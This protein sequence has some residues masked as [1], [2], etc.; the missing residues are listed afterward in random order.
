MLRNAQLRIGLQGC[1][2]V[3]HTELILKINLQNNF[4]F[5]LLKSFKDQ[6]SNSDN[7]IIQKAKIIDIEKN[8]KGFKDAFINT[9]NTNISKV[10][11]ISLE[12]KVLLFLL[13]LF[14]KIYHNIRKTKNNGH[15]TFEFS[16]F[17]NRIVNI[18][19]LLLV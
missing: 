17:N 14:N 15:E 2:L 8:D 7:Q 12:K 13:S 5:N 1:I 10:K 6:K 3:D 9:K 19:V 4:N 16:S 11:L 18:K